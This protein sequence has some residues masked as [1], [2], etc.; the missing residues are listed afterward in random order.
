MVGLAMDTKASL[1]TWRPSS[2]PPVRPID[3]MTRE[4]PDTTMALGACPSASSVYPFP[5]KNAPKL[6]VLLKAVSGPVTEMSA[7]RPI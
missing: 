5:C 2:V 7:V 3:E 4:P 1:L 6:A